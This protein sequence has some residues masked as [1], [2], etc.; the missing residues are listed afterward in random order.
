MC[1]PG[2]AGDGSTVE[3]AVFLAS[4]HPSFR[5]K[6][7]KTMVIIAGGACRT[8]FDFRDSGAWAVITWHVS[9]WLA[10]LSSWLAISR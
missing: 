9:D 3:D 6:Y 4:C 5:M 1:L 8:Y 10:I 2:T 7:K